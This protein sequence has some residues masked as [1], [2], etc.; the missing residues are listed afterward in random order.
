MFIEQGNKEFLKIF[1]DKADLIGDGPAFLAVSLT[2]VV[3]F[4]VRNSFWKSPNCWFAAKIGCAI[5]KTS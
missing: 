4:L 1:L 5:L 2:S 3:E